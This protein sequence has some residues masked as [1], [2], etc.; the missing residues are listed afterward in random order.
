MYN[1]TPHTST[2]L[3]PF[4]IFMG[5]E[6]T[7]QIDL[8]LGLVKEETAI[9]PDLEAWVKQHQQKLRNAAALAREKMEEKAANRCKQNDTKA[10]DSGNP[11]GDVVLL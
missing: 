2:G 10:N 6:P 9:E 5:R 8:M 3:S 7:L 4:S 1:C 11:I